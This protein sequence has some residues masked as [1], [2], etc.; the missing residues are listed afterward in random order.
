MLDTPTCQMGSFRTACSSLS[1]V[2]Y[3]LYEIIA[4]AFIVEKYPGILKVVIELCL[5]APYAG[6]SANDIG[7]PSKH[8]KCSILPDRCVAD[9]ILAASIEGR[10]KICWRPYD[11]EAL[12]VNDE[13]EKHEA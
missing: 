10:V 5:Y 11:G 13:F 9:R 12:D 7:I 3:L 2:L 8:D 4:P 1:S 6:H